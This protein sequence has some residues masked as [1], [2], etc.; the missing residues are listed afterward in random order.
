[1]SITLN[2]SE[3]HHPLDPLLWASILED[4]KVSGVLGGWNVWIH[5]KLTIY[6][7]LETKG[8][9]G[10]LAH[11]RRQSSGEFGKLSHGHCQD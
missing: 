7:T 5:E 10:V 6:F 11:R 2:L 4:G 9:G 3:G 8:M 1:M